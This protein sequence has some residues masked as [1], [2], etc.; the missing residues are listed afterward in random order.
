MNIRHFG[1]KRP[2]TGSSLSPTNSSIAPGRQ[3]ICCTTTPSIRACGCAARTRASSAA[4]SARTCSESGTNS[5]IGSTQGPVTSSNPIWQRAADWSAKAQSLVRVMKIRLVVF[6][7]HGRHETIDISPVVSPRIASASAATGQRS[8]K[9]AI[10]AASAAWKMSQPQNAW[11]VLVP[12]ASL[13]RRCRDKP[14]PH[15]YYG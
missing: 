10:G 8:S 13:L 11:P 4:V 7:Q 3:T 2:K 9:S 1:A 15:S 14:S 12:G 6:L 5:V